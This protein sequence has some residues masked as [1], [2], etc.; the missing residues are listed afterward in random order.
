MKYVWLLLLMFA[1]GMAARAQIYATDGSS[2]GPD[3]N[4]QEYF[5]QSPEDYDRS[6]IYIFFNNE[7]CYACA[8]T[9]GM[10]NQI[11]DRYFAGQY[12]LLM[13]NYDNDQENE[14]IYTYNLRQPLAVV[15]VRINDGSAFGWRKLTGLENMISDP[16][17]FEEY[18][19]SEVTDFLGND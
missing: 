8:Q 13:I 17:S 4:L 10:I 6:V 7:P 15:L 19:V 9:I 2:Y 16:V 11:Y 3:Q 12:T 5:E 18:F 14:F 1:F